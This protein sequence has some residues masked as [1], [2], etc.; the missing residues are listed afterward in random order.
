MKKDWE[1]AGKLCLGL[2]LPLSVLP[3]LLSGHRTY[4]LH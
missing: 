4:L 3:W 2:L 1:E